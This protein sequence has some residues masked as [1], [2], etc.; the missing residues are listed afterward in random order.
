MLEAKVGNFIIESS[1]LDLHYL[2]DWLPKEILMKL[3]AFP[4]LNSL[5]GL[6][7]RVW[8]CIING[9]LI[10]RMFMSLF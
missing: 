4:T 5:N 7:Y 6:D 9:S 1:D 10:L 8:K 3:N 2:Q